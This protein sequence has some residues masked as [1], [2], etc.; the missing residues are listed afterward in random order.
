MPASRPTAKL[1]LPSEHAEEAAVP[2]LPAPAVGPPFRDR[3]AWVGI[4]V[5][6][7]PGQ[8]RTRL[9]RQFLA[10]PVFRSYRGGPDLAPVN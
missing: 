5:S 1:V 6:I 10:F 2:P 3:H 4:S 9:P 8:P 7:R